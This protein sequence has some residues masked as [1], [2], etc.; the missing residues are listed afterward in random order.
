[1]KIHNEF[2]D[3]FTSIGCFKGTFKLQVREGS[4]PY[5]ALPR[6]V[7]YALQEQL[8]EE[9]DR[10]QK[11]QII[12]PLDTDETLEWCNIFILVP[13][14]KSKVSQFLDPAWINK[15]L[16]RPIHRGPSLTTSYLG[17][18]VLKYLVFID[19]SSGYHDLKLDKQSLYLKTF[20]CPFGGYRYM[21]MCLAL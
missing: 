18:K 21:L 9:L 8:W 16:I 14:V 7:A 17:W 1:M 2:S 12:V 19:T 3:N 15:V 5:Q 10:L 4:H 6:R 11:H 13:K 20:S